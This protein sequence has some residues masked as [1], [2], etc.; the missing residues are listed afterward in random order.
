MKANLEMTEF[1]IHGSCITYHLV[2]QQA[3]TLSEI[4]R[5]LNPELSRVRIGDG[6]I[7]LKRETG[8]FVLT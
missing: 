1:D 7:K 5:D 6:S 8:S 2:N 3:V 4:V